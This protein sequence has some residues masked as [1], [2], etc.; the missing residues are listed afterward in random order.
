MSEDSVCGVEAP[1]G[2]FTC[3]L[4]EGHDGQHATGLGDVTWTQYA[5]GDPDD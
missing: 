3:Q 5:G 1:G 2:M 4:P